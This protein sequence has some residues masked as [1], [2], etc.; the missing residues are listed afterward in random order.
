MLLYKVN[1]Y[2]I[3]FSLSLV[4]VAFSATLSLD[5]FFILGLCGGSVS[6]VR[7]VWA[8]VCNRATCIACADPLIVLQI[9]SSS[10]VRSH[11]SASSSGVSLSD[12]CSLCTLVFGTFS[13]AMGAN[14]KRIKCILEISV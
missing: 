3:S 2:H 4:W 8:L 10:Y 14:T 1:V 13:S 9:L 5:S 7:L 12:N 6:T 11:G